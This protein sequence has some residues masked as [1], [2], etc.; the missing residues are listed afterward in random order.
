MTNKVL[1]QKE[2]E[3]KINSNVEKIRMF[4]RKSQEAKPFI[5]ENEKLG[6][7]WLEIEYSTKAAHI[8]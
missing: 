2:I 1:R 5:E 8:C 3:R 6:E 4:G 7:E